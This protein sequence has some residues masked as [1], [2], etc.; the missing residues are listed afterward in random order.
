MED[1]TVLIQCFGIS[2]FLDEHNNFFPEHNVLFLKHNR[3]N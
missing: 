2:M 1:A 3:R